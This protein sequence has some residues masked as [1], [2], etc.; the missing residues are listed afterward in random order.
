MECND[1]EMG[2][3]TGEKCDGNYSGYRYYIVSARIEFIQ[4]VLSL[5]TSLHN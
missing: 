3:T 1:W 5:H 2:T 4:K